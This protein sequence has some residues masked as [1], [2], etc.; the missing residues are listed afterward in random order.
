MEPPVLPAVSPMRPVVSSV[1]LPIKTCNEGKWELGTDFGDPGAFGQIW[2][3]CCGK[4]CKYILKYQSYTKI[5]SPTGQYITAQDPIDVRQEVA[6]QRKMYDIGIAPQ[7][8]DF[9]ECNHGASFIMKAL[10]ETVY[11]LIA[12]F[13]EEK[14]QIA[15][16]CIEVV[17]K[18]HYAGYYHRDLHL[19]NIMV[20]YDAYQ[21]E[22]KD[23]DYRYYLIDFGLS[24]VLIPN[25]DGVSFIKSDYLKLGGELTNDMERTDSRFIVLHEMLRDAEQKDIAYLMS[26]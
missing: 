11:S 14:E 12:R 26:R 15:R 8:L 9:F 20:D 13:G 17:S 7:I 10:R 16:R 19:K 23:E 22:Y 2:L 1:C 3:A 6:I 25:S 24:G 18:M 21:T 4:E 5:I